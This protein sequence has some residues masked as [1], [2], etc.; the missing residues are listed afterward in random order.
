M[1]FRSVIENGKTTLGF[2]PLDDGS[3]TDVDDNP[4]ELPSDARVRVAHDSNLNADMTARWQQ[5]LLDY[6]VNPLFQ[7]LGKGTYALTEN[8]RKET[9]I[10]DF[11]GYLLEAFALRGRALKLGYTRGPAEDGGWFHVYEKRFPT[12]GLTAVIEFT[13]N[14][15]PEENRTVALIKLS[16]S[17]A[18]DQSWQRGELALENVPKVLLSECYNDV[19]LIAADGSGY[20]SEWQKKA[21]Y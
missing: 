8:K 1:L 11:E 15:L 6:E 21:E 20:D 17:P 4:V 16:F 10:A 19:R 14:P 3:L 2:R 18:S 13:G 7:Q 9:A 5:H 12:L